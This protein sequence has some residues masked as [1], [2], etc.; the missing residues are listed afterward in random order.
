MNKPVHIAIRAEDRATVDAFYKAAIAAGGRDN[1]PPGI[2]PH[3]HANCYGA[4][5]LDPDGHNIEAVC[6]AAGIVGFRAPRHG[7]NIGPSASLLSFGQQIAKMPMPIE[8]PEIPPA[9]PGTPTEPPPGIPPGNPQPDMAPP[10]R[11]PGDTGGRRTNCRAT[12]RRDSTTRTKWTTHA[13]SRNGRTFVAGIIHE[14]S[15]HMCG[16]CNLRLNA[17]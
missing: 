16:D 11:E 14:A 10:V 6:H 5:V 9:T 3:Y 4:F 13:Q 17:Q 2:R 15:Q 12:Y 1:G 7:R 8:P